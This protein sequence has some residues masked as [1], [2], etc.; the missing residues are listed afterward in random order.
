M[1]S[2]LI[3]WQVGEQRPV[4]LSLALGWLGGELSAGLAGA[5]FHRS[6][7]YT[8]LSQAPSRVL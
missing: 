7:H 1:C 5:T 8:S 2:F 3:T 4:L 6:Q